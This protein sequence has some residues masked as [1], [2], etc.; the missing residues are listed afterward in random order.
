MASIIVLVNIKEE[1][2]NNVLV[3]LNCLSLRRLFQRTGRDNSREGVNPVSSTTSLLT[4]NLTHQLPISMNNIITALTS[5][6]QSSL[7]ETLTLLIDR[8]ISY[9]FIRT[10]IFGQ[11]WSCLFLH[12]ISVL[13]LLSQLLQFLTSQILKLVPSTP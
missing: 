2:N 10:S 1:I 8:I 13:Q 12:K 4:Q 3:L 5:T 9:F 7:K 6:K 11:Y